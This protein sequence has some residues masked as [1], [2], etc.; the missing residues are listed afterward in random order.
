MAPILIL[1]AG[2]TEALKQACRHLAQRGFSVTDD[3]SPIVTHVLLPVPSFDASGRII[4]GGDVEMLL[5]GL[6]KDITIIGGKLDHPTLHGYK[7]VDLLADPMYLA[8]NAR[9]TAYCALQVAMDALPRTLDGLPVLVIGWGRIGK[10]LTQLLRAI[11]ADVTVAARKETDRAA[12]KS[13]GYKAQGIG[14]I[15]S[16]QYGLIFNTAPQMVLP[17]CPGNA[18][19]IDLASQPGITGD[20][21]LDARGLP[22]KY[23]SEE[24]GRLIA[25]TILR[26]L[27]EEEE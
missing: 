14:Q 27:K 4:G 1:A 26:I 24:S 13:L 5:G 12:L 17:D 11:G 16:I 2:Q 20:N 19:K 18:R 3:P 6:S 9:I 8:M 21:I 23:A 10:C 25:E 22:G 15:D 7:K